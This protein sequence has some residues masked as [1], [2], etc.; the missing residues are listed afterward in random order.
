MISHDKIFKKVIYL[1]TIITLYILLIAIIVGM[2]NVF[3]N[4]GYAWLEKGGFG[5]IVYSILTIFVLIDFFKAFA[6]YR[7]HERIKL[8]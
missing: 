4:I 3:R 7:I 2:F 6:D 8:T 1:V 5:Q